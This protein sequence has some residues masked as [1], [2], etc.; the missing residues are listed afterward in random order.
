MN[1][2]EL[3]DNIQEIAEDSF[4]ADQIALFVQQAEQNVYNTVQ[5]P[6]MRETA[7]PT[8]SAGTA[9][10]AVPADFLYTY[11]LAVVLGSGAYRYLLNKDVNFIREAYPTPSATGTPVHYAYSEDSGDTVLFLGPTPDATY[12]LDLTYARYPESIVT[13]GTTWL[14][15]NY[16]NVL[17]NGALLEAARFQQQEPDVIQNYE[18]LYLQSV[19]LIK[20]LGDGYLRQDVYRS[21]QVREAVS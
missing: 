10:V 19:A 20:R 9:T 11:G 1:Y 3:S 15:D 4:T 12:T 5:L 7:T 16:D 18:K 21:G 6:P 14:G 17:L 13:A 2:T 8:T